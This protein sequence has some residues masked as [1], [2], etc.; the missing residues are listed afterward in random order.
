MKRV[1]LSAF[2]ILSSA[3]A[4][5]AC[6]PATTSSNSANQPSATESPVNVSTSQTPSGF[7]EALYVFANPD[8]KE[9]IKQGKFQSGLEHYEKV[10]QTAKKPDG[11]R[12]ESFFTGTNGNDTVQ[13]FGKGE[14]AHFAGV[15]IEIVDQEGVEFPLRPT[16]LGQGETD[17]LIGTTEGGNEFLL[18]SFITPVHP[19]AEPFYL[20]KGDADYARI[21]NFT[22]S[23]D[24][25]ILAG[26]PDQYKME[27]VDG[28]VRILL[29]GDLVAIVEGVEKLTV[30]DVVKEYGVFTMK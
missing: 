24:S 3:I 27:T 16:S 23:K 13:G 5:A 11:E 12:Y 20:G 18:G 6:A 28:N 15:K 9:L 30:G 19:K 22:P 29:N 25:V 2:L 4:L 1:L 17:V 8:V 7:D 21:Q 26:K 14:H 10:G